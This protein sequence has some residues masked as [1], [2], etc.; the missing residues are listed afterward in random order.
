M[1]NKRHWIR[2][3]QILLTR[4]PVLIFAGST[5]ISFI[6]GWAMD[7]KIFSLNVLQTVL[8]LMTLGT[9]GQIF[10]LSGDKIAE[11]VKTELKEEDDDA[12]E[13]NLDDLYDRLKKDKD[14]RTEK[15]LRDL[16][17]L[18]N[19]IKESTGQESTLDAQTIFELHFKVEQ[20]F[21]KCISRLEK[22]LKLWK[23]AKDISNRDVSEKLLTLREEVVT[24]VIQNIAHLG[25]MLA[26]IQ[27]LNC[28]QDSSKEDLQNIRKDLEEGLAIA[29]QVDEKMRKFEKGENQFE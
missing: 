2:F 5:S 21:N 14:S 20:L 23:S 7:F 19:A 16:R 22:S 10:F 12:R 9:I 26:R 11:R 27:T 6:A 29:E 8:F 3:I 17:E 18:S 24:E 13:Q 28:N 4:I 25:E 15:A 1:S